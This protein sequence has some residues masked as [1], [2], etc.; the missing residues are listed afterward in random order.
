ME[1]CPDLQVIQMLNELRIEQVMLKE[2][3]SS[4]QKASQSTQRSGNYDDIPKEVQK[5]NSSDQ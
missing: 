2:Q 5:D 3:L 4:L 1:M